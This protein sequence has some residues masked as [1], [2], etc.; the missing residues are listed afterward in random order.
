MSSHRCSIIRFF[1]EFAAAQT[2]CAWQMR[3]GL[4][5]PL[6]Q[7]GKW[8]LI[9]SFLTHS[10]VFGAPYRYVPFDVPGA[11]S[12]FL[13]GIN[14]YGQ[15][16]GRYSGPTGAGAFL[17]DGSAFIDLPAHNGDEVLPQDINE[18]G[19]IVG[20]LISE[21]TI[22][23][24]L[25]THGFLLDAGA[26]TVIDFPG[27]TYTG[28]GGLNNLGEIVGGY[29]TSAGLGPGHGFSFDGTDF[30]SID[31]PDA[32]STQATGINDSGRI[33]GAFHRDNLLFGTGYAFQ[34][35]QFEILDTPFAQSLAPDD[36]NS[37]GVIAGTYLFSA[38]NSPFSGFVLDGPFVSLVHFPGAEETRVQGINDHNHLIGTYRKFDGPFR[39]FI[40]YPVPEP[41]TLT[42]SMASMAV[43]AII[44]RLR[45][46][47]GR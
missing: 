46:L 13:D 36:V 2:Y 20:T 45:A 39:G 30:R 21:S 12:T 43:L 18:L 11:T 44:R 17:Y 10:S 42:F 4:M 3:R 33:V 14:N 22:P 1:C 47:T 40:A 8:L 19:Q 25:D 29:T 9:V 37:S 6:P 38:F 5:W 31:V 26:F 7:R 35:G 41:T 23:G 34:N 24:L 15:I 27:A 32:F 16:V 28:I